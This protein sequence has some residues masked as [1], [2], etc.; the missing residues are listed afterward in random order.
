M[1]L[2]GEGRPLLLN[3]DGMTIEQDQAID[4][5]DQAPPYA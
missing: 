1:I 4:L 2:M 5:L 3:E